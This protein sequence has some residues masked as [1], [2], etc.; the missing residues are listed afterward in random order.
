MRPAGRMGILMG[1][2]KCGLKEPY[3]MLFVNGFSGGKILIAS[4]ATIEFK[5]A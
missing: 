2:S 4:K 1:L 5:G 3:R